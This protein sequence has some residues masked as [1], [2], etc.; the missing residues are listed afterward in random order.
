MKKWTEAILYGANVRDV[1]NS[2]DSSILEIQLELTQFGFIYVDDESDLMVNKDSGYSGNVLYVLI[3][4]E[5]ENFKVVMSINSR[6]EETAESQ[7]YKYYCLIPRKNSHVC[8]AYLQ[9]L[10]STV[11]SSE[12]YKNH[13]APYSVDSDDLNVGV[14][15]IILNE[16]GK[17]LVGTRSDGKGLCGPGGCVKK[18]ESLKEAA[19]R[20][21]E[22]EFSIIPK[23]LVLIGKLAGDSDHKPS[24]IFRT[25]EYSGEVQV[26]EKGMLDYNWLSVEELNQKDN[27]FRAFKESLNLLE[28]YDEWLFNEHR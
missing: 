20:E 12:A 22:E 19:K 11:K 27:L 3:I 15:V 25:S 10:I 2:T 18:G 13:S 9:D 5:D 17:I 8:K 6:P 28:L 26:D 4:P 14:G 23:H 1:L 7:G 16:E 24:Y 21:T